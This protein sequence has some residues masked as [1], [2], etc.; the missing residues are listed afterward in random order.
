VEDVEDID[1]E[2]V[3]LFTIDVV[4]LEG[5][6][7]EDEVVDVLELT[8]EVEELVVEGIEVVL[9]DARDNPAAAPAITI[10]TTITTMTKTLLTAFSV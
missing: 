4:E 6:D 3:E 7:I 1:D 9:F 2:K 5:D 8:D 10:I